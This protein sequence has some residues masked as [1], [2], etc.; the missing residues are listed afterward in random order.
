MKLGLWGLAAIPM[1]RVLH[2]QVAD[3]AT[4]EAA[5]VAEDDPVGQALGYVHDATKADVAK[6]PKKAR[7]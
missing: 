3:A 6:F 1:H 4:S 7:C 2:G 5:K